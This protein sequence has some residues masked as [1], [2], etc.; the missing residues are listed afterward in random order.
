MVA[1]MS[2]VSSEEL[3][4]RTSEVLDRVAAGET[5]TVMR[6]GNAVA[7]FRPVQSK[8]TTRR[9]SGLAKGQFVVPDDFDDPLPDEILREFEGR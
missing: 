5:V 7:E 4:D 9:P 8:R 2:T 3:H 6:E 1:V